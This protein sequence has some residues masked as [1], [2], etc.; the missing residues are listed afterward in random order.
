MSTATTAPPIVLAAS[1]IPNPS[2]SSNNMDLLVPGWAVVDGPIT[3]NWGNRQC[4]QAQ[5]VM[6]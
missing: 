2:S 3:A 1:A 4:E 6:N 5:G